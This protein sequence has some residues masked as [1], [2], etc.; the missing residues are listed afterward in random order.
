M[1]AIV[2][3]A[4]LKGFDVAELIDADLSEKPREN[5]CWPSVAAVDTCTCQSKLAAA[6]NFLFG[7]WRCSIPTARRSHNAKSSERF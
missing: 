3:E 2:E 4:S 1:K 5:Y 7:R 6:G